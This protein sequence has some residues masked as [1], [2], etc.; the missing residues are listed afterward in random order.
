MSISSAGKGIIVIAALIIVISLAGCTQ[1][2]AKSTTA[3]SPQGSPEG[4]AQQTNYPPNQV[5]PEPV[6]PV[7]ET[8]PTLPPETEPAPNEGGS[9]AEAAGSNKEF[10][11]IA[12]QWE[13]EPSQIRVSE[14]DTVTLHIT[15]ED[16]THGISIPEFGIN[17]N[18]APGQ[19]I[20]VTFTADKKGVFPFVCSVYCGS[21]HGGMTGEIIVE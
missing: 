11:V 17:E 9:S 1:T 5:P 4:G 13:F 19:T 16:V 12:R 10:D 20:T 7:Q 15:S 6:P 3:A 2:T 14:G 21:G 18:L 8:P